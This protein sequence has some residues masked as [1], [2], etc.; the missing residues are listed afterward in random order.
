LIKKEANPETK[1]RSRETQLKFILLIRAKA[2]HYDQKGLYRGN[3]PDIH[4]GLKNEKFRVQKE[5]IS[6]YGILLWLS[7]P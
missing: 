2:S 1:H 6:Y 4:P 7:I 3:D 5:H